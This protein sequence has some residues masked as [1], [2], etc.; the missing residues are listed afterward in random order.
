MHVHHVVGVRNLNA[1]RKRFHAVV[2]EALQNRL[3]PAH[4]HNVQPFFLRRLDHRQT[5]QPRNSDIRNYY[6][7]FLTSDHFQ[8]LDSVI[9]SPYYLIIQ[10]QAGN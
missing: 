1:C 7:R 6:I 4:Q 5:I 9:S 3:A 8:S 2:L 10:L